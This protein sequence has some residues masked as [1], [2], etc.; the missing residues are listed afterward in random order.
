[1]TGPVRRIEG[2]AVSD[3]FRVTI[4]GVRSRTPAAP[5]AAALDAVA[6]SGV[7]NRGDHSELVVRFDKGATPRYRVE[8][9]G[10]TLRVAIEQTPA[11][12]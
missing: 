8:A 7:F 11:A 1:M 10:S 4:P 9:R 2:E 5:I 12:R 3:G 6:G